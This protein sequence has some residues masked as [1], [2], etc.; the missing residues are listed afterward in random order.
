MNAQQF[1]RITQTMTPI[2]QWMVTFENELK[3]HKDNFEEG[4]LA[5]LAQRFHEAESRVRAT[6][7]TLLKIDL[8]LLITLTAPHFND[9]KMFGFNVKDIVFANEAFLI[10]SSV[11]FFFVVW[12]FV[13][14]RAYEAMVEAICKQKSVDPTWNGRYLTSSYIDQ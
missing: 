2:V 10:A 4:L 12:Q 8:V 13:T 5:R 1:Q 14:A 7:Q 6:G 11:A 3:L 9:G